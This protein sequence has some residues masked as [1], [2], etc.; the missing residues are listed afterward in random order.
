MSRRVVELKIIYTYSYFRWGF[1]RGIRMGFI[2]GITL[3][4]H[5]L[6]PPKPLLTGAVRGSAGIP[7]SLVHKPVDTSGRATWPAV[8]FA[9]LAH[10]A[11]PAYLIYSS[12]SSLFCFIS[13]PSFSLFS[14]PPCRACPRSPAPARPA[15]LRESAGRSAAILT[16]RTAFYAPTMAAARPREKSLE[17]GRCFPL[18]TARRR[19]IIELSPGEPETTPNTTPGASYV[20]RTT[21]GNDRETS[22]EC[23]PA[24]HRKDHPR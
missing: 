5:P 14:T 8:P 12:P 7:D 3:D 23:A 17:N 20:R 21:P 18:R 15:D 6:R 10:L 4:D 11:I 1:I 9:C 19:V 13:H 22:A 16:V 24:H 2:R